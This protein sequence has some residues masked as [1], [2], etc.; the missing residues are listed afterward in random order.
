MPVWVPITDTP[1]NMCDRGGLRGDGEGEGS[2][3]LSLLSYTLR[4]VSLADVDRK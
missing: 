1:V 4:Y 3:V 2:E